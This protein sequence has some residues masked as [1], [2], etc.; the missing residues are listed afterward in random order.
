LRVSQD[1]QKKGQQMT[2]RII[3]SGDFERNHAELQSMFQLRSKVFSGKL[4][5][6]VSV[7]DGAERDIYDEMNP[8]YIVKLAP[9]TSDVIASMRL[10]PTTGPTLL[11]EVFAD[12]IPD[13]ASLSAPSIWECTRFCID[14]DHPL[15]RNNRMDMMNLTS[16]MLLACGEVCVRSGIQSIVANFEENS[17]RLYKL[18]GAPVDI[19]G[20][21]N[22]YGEKTV[23]LGMFS[24]DAETIEEIKSRYHVRTHLSLHPQDESPDSYI[25]VAA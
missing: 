2:I 6:D 21:S 24:F 14:D 20:S 10:M 18:L 25:G 5:W 19:L 13:G 23:H 22:A 16:K 17:I 1:V 11:S 9:G 7:Q 4:G 12:T 8:V 15:V 3:Q